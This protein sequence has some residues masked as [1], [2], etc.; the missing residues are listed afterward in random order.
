[1]NV[2][3][4][5][6]VCRLCM[7]ENIVMFRISEVIS[8]NLT[9]FEF[10][11]Q[12]ADLPL[13]LELNKHIID[14]QLICESCKRFCQEVLNFRL[15]IS[16]NLECFQQQILI[17]E[18]D[19]EGEEEIEYEIETLNN[20]I[21]AMIGNICDE[22]EDLI[23]E[24]ILNI[25]E[26]RK[27][28]TEFP[29]DDEKYFQETITKIEKYICPIKSCKETFSSK[30]ALNRHG[31]KMHSDLFVWIGE[32]DFDSIVCIICGSQFQTRTE[33]CEHKKYHKTDIQE[34]SAIKCRY[35]QK[36]YKSLINLTNH[37]KNHDEAKHF[38]CLLCKERFSDF[39][40]EIQDHILIHQ[41]STPHIC[42]CGKTFNHAAEIKIHM[43]THHSSHSSDDSKK[44]RFILFLSTKHE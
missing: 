40:Q 44:V 41:G 14:A 36:P 17:K 34:K 26:E 1:M 3:N 42:I 5:M 23:E 30:R 12:I 4:Q 33:L 27:E 39:G 20:P 11:H 28:T 6:D 24:T 32:T 43:R 21:Q 9:Y 22:T 2:F 35:C 18:F 7:S 8:D 13:P 15:M 29:D 31:V 19:E 37:L 38:L 10:S 25:K 16:K